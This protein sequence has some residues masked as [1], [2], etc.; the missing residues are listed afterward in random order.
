MKIFI[1]KIILFSSMILQ[2]IL[3]QNNVKNPF[4]NLKSQSFWYGN[5]NKISF[6][7]KKNRK[8]QIN[9]IINQMFYMNSNLPN[10]YIGYSKLN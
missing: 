3:A 4:N 9:M 10:H 6:L 7:D 8:N 1:K 5:Y 2:F